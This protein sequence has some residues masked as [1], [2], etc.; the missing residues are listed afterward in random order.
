M[1]REN[2]FS[3]GDSGR[4]LTPDLPEVEDT[5]PQPLPT[6]R[7][8][9][10]A[11][12][13]TQPTGG[14]VQPV[15]S[16]ATVPSR[17]SVR[18]TFGVSA[19]SDPLD[20]FRAS[21]HKVIRLHRSSTM[22]ADRS[23]IGAEPGVDP[24]R[25]SAFAAYGH[26]RQ[27]CFIEVVDYSAVRSS[28]GRMSNKT[29]INMLQ[30][31]GASAREPWVKVRWI[32][33]GGISWDVM[34][35]LALK[36][37]LHPLALEDVL[38]Q[39]GHARSKADYYSNHLF[40]RVLCHALARDNDISTDTVDP[41]IEIPRSFSPEPMDDVDEN[42]VNAEGSEKD[43]EKTVFGTASVNRLSGVPGI[44]GRKKPYRGKK[45]H[46]PEA[47]NGSFTKLI[48]RGSTAR[49]KR[50]QQEKTIDELKKGE[51][52]NVKI[53]PMHIF[54][55]RDGTVISIHPTP[56]LDYTAPIT[57]RLRTRDGMLRTT[58]DASLLVQSLLDLVVDS[59]LQVVDE[60]HSKILKLEHDILLH[61]KMKTIRYLHILSGDL[62]LHKRTLEPIKTV[63]YG[64]RRYDLDRCAAL[65]DTTNT[66]EPAKV[67]GYMS[68][69]AKIYLAD[70]F[71]H[72]EH[73]LTSL[74]MFASIS[75]NLINFTF[76][77]VSNDMNQVMRR[78]TLATII[79]LPLTLLTGYFCPAALRSPVGSCNFIPFWEIAIPV[80]I[81]VTS[82][83][84]WRDVMGAIHYVKKRWLVKQGNQK[85][86]TD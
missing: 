26:L 23:D 36:Y 1:P 48:H 50:I 8:E 7:S 45:S 34:S 44:G 64:L 80:M 31:E 67:Q 85:W 30:H 46:D 66:N 18:P 16:E 86:K 11:I 51:R 69:K 65:V 74:D 57:N 2:S 56:S 15:M 84:M 27:N 39:R 9:A 19:Q 32:N 59:A 60:Y 42:G 53:S 5:V 40:L 28:F 17:P 43:D 22:F 81:V 10:P 38:H 83:F 3:D 68:H 73:I 61:P 13:V 37:N 54:L 14:S 6:T 71:D 4:S 24:R 29:F 41:D 49:V 75:E 70:V 25:D 35:A 62:I 63:I 79:F 76:N 12:A 78:L 72:M 82:L 58:A 52:V 47:Q 77:M 33:I 55:L 21:V 20:R